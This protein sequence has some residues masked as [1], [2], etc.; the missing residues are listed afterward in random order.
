MPEIGQTYAGQR[1]G[2]SRI[3]ARGLND[4]AER[5]ETLHAH[6][7]E[8]AGRDNDEKDLTAAFKDAEAQIIGGAEAHPLMDGRNAIDAA[9]MQ[10]ATD[11]AERVADSKLSASEKQAQA[12]AA[13]LADVLT[14][15]GLV[16]ESPSPV[17]ADEYD[18]PEPDE[19]EAQD[20][21]SLYG[22]YDESEQHWYATDED[23]HYLTN[24]DGSYKTYEDVVPEDQ[25]NENDENLGWLE[26]VSTDEDGWPDAE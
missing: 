5:Q 10:S 18:E 22:W 14:E 15:R 3:P 26:E 24:P 11:A 4:E 19:P 13:A 6:V 20:G 25:L 2:P 7:A 9:I 8:S 17:A 16:T 21:G 23:G 1:R 12:T